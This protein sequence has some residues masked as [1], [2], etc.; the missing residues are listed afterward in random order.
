[1]KNR[2]RT[3]KKRYPIEVHYG[4]AVPQLLGVESVQRTVEAVAQQ[5]LDD[6]LEHELERALEQADR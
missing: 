1:M 5:R 6:R 4:P 2:S 3:T